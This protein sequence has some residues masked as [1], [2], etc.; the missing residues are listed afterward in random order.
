M[1]FPWISLDGE[2]IGWFSYTAW[3]FG[4]LAFIVWCTPLILFQ[5]QR[6]IQKQPFHVNLPL[7]LLGPL[8]AFVGL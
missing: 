5:G 1:A 3:L 8:T 6:I 7:I 2:I 4:W